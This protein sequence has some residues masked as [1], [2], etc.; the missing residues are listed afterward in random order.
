MELEDPLVSSVE[1]D[2]VDQ[3]REW[4]R[5]SESDGGRGRDRG[6]GRGTSVRG[7]VRGRVRGKRRGR[8][9][10]GGGGEREAGVFKVAAQDCAVLLVLVREY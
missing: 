8:G 9:E 2:N 6:R 5:G 4:E 10:G 7:N 1:D 3:I